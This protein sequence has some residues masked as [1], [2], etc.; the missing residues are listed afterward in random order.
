[1]YE[2]H[3]VAGRRHNNCYVTLHK[4]TGKT[5]DNL[6]GRE[7]H[8]F[9]TTKGGFV[10]PKE[11]YQIARANNQLRMPHVDGCMELLTSEDLY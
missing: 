1:M 10:T 8:G 6:P 4:L 7:A 9:L 2:N 5:L 11:A 3:P